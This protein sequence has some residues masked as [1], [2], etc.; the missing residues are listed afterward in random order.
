MVCLK[1][2]WHKNL[3]YINPMSRKLSRRKAVKTTYKKQK[4]PEWT[5]EKRIKAEKVLQKTD[6]NIDRTSSSVKVVIDYE[7]YFPFGHS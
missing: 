2:S 5:E 6:Q 3:V 1:R 4:V 7:S